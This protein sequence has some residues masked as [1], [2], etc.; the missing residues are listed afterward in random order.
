MQLKNIVVASLLALGAA[1][2]AIAAPAGEGDGERRV[3]K[4]RIHGKGGHPPSVE[5]AAMHNIMAELL[6]AKTGKTTAEIQA[7]F[8]EGGPHSVAEKLGLKEGDMKP[9][10]KEARST[11]ITRAAAAGL[12]TAQQAEKL[13][14]AKIEMK[15]RHKHGPDGDDDDDE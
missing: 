5:F 3:Y 7:L 9:L 12:I 1:G 8:E 6:S 13:R 4:Q 2:I 10:F 11:L 15:F 14:A